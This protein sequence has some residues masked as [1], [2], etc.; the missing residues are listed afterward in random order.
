MGAPDIF[1]EHRKGEKVCKHIRV[2]PEVSHVFVIG[3]SREANLRIRGE[4]IMGCHAVL[5]YRAPDWF[6][7][8][9]SG[10]E[11]LKVDGNV[12]SEARIDASTRVELA[13][14]R[15][16]LFARERESRLF[17]QE[18]EG[19]DLVLHQIVIRSHGRVVETHLRS[20]REV[21]RYF[22][23]DKFVALPAPQEGRW[24]RTEFG[25][26]VVEQRLV[27]SQ[28]IVSRDTTGLDHEMK[29]ALLGS[30]VFMLLLF[31]MMFLMASKGSE[32]SA[33]VA[34]DKKSIDVIFNAKAVKKKQLESQ[35]VLKSSRSRAGG[36][37][38]TSPQPQQAKA[39]TQPEESTAPTSFGK[40]SAALTSIRQSGLS[41]LVGKIAKRANKQ[42]QLVAANGVTAD[43]Q[44]TGRALFSVGTATTGGGGV[45]SKE[46]TT[47][48]L[49]G[50]ATQGKAGGGAAFREGTALAG[51]GVGT[52]NI[53][54]LVDEE[55]VIEGGLDRDAIAEVIKRNIGQIR[56]CY[57]RQL[58]SNR[59]LYGKVLVKFT[60]GASGDVIDQKVDSSTLKS[61]MVEGCI[62]RRLAG[63]KFPLPKGGTNVNVSYPFLF[64]AL[65]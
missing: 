51:A 14:H 13:G 4:G 63:W 47:F 23:G 21:F 34:L 52:G 60:I 3:S 10:T 45:A 16:H 33:E 42:N 25:T 44:G 12:V 20:A 62:L 32:T 55:T 18:S 40:T 31:G 49:G 2:K 53:V 6:I 48:R 46:G 39:S 17:R 50:V 5:R 26:R 35:K 11:S 43:R 38:D 24:Q 30:A 65:D 29:R 61:A 15:L 58:S 27:S 7:C 64:K 57:E 22:D 36:T 56:Y 9:V 8:D 37:T 19:G 28:E 1:L 41:V 59:D 54:A